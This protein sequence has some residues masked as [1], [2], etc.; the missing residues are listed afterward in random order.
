MYAIKHIETLFR[1]LLEENKLSPSRQKEAAVPADE[2]KSL[3]GQSPQVVQEGQ[4][5]NFDQ[6]QKNEEQK[7]NRSRK[8]SMA[9]NEGK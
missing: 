1:T 8:N 9:S 6:E 2:S 7:S 5:F 4:Q 3:I